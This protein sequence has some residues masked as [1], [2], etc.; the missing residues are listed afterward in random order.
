M[1]RDMDL[2]RQ[3]LLRVE[4]SPPFEHIFASNMLVDGYNRDEIIYHVVQLIDA[5]LLVGKVMSTMDGGAPE[6]VVTAMTWEGHEFID[7]ARADTVWNA[8]KAQAK[9]MAGSLTFGAMKTLL[10]AEAA[11]LLGSR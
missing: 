2:I 5:G 10:I 9:K 6:C 4:A 1:K 3:I 8:A 11:K 7:A